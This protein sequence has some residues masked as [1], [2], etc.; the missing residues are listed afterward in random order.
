MMQDATLPW[1]SLKHMTAEHFTRALDQ[2]AGAAP[3]CQCRENLAGP[4]IFMIPSIAS[5]ETLGSY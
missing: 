4:C 1:A 5:Y 2:A 3:P